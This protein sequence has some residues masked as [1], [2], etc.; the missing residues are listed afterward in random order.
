MD[1]VHENKETQ[2]MGFIYERLEILRGSKT[3]AR[4]KEVRDMVPAT[5]RVGITVNKNKTWLA[6]CQLCNCTVDFIQ[7]LT[8]ESEYKWQIQG[9]SNLPK[10]CIIWM[11]LNRHDLN[12]IVTK[13]FNTRKNFISE[14][15]ISINY[16]LLH[17]TTELINN[18][19]RSREKKTIS[20]WKTRKDRGRI[21]IILNR[22]ICETLN[23]I[24]KEE[25]G[26]IFEV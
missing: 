9:I 4:S 1:N 5:E 11:F 25:T 8:I 3:T 10:T 14:V 21:E 20:T 23:C 12:C 18:E 26:Q 13:S 16:W 2:L 19:E 17:Q 7:K 15:G 6:T 22:Y 24:L